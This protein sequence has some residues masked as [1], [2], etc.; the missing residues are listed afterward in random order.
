MNTVMRPAK[1]VYR[2]QLPSPITVIL[3]GGTSHVGKSTLAR[4][5]ADELAWEHRATDKLAKHPGRPWRND[6][7]ELASHVREHYSSLAADEL[8]EDVLK[9]YE[10]NVLPQVESVIR[11]HSSDPSARGLVLEG[12]ALWPDFVAPLMSERVGAV[13]L[14]GGDELLTKRVHTES[15]Y[16]QKRAEDQL[17]IDAFL[18]RTLGF[19]SRLERVIDDQGL[20]TIEL[21]EAEPIETLAERCLRAVAARDVSRGRVTASR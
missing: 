2:G 4:H 17:L 20:P 6:G 5:L 21:R 12:S 16:P 9:H 19:A 3:I 7:G 8:I 13:W 18:K 14:I 1:P 11:T 15:H 10:R